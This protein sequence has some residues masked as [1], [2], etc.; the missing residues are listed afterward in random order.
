MPKASTQALMEAAI[1]HWERNN[2]Q[3]TCGTLVRM[4]TSNLLSL[5]DADIA[6]LRQARALL[7]TP[8]KRKPGR[9]KSTAALK[10]KPKQKRNLSPEGRARIVAAVKRRWAAKKKASGK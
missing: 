6:V 2:R 9:P 8:E 10:A 1:E 4:T 3:A 7:S 5:I